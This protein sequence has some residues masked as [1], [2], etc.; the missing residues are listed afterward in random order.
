MPIKSIVTFIHDH[1][2]DQHVLATAAALADAN[3]AHLT[4]VC[5]G[6]DPT[7]PGA[8]YAGA[9][10]IVLESSLGRAQEEA[11]ATQKAVEAQLGVWTIPWE[12][13]VITSQ[14][15]ALSIAVGER[16][17][18]ADLIVLPKPYGKDRGAEDVV[19]TEAALFRTRVPVL[20]VPEGQNGA[21]EPMSVVVAWNQGPEALAAVRGAMPFLQAAEV[22]DLA[23]I[24]PPQHG[25][26]RSDPG[27]LLATML[28]RYNVRGNV[29]ILSKTM[30]RVSDVLMR[31]CGD[32]SAQLL[33]MGAYGHSR[34]LEAVLGGTTRNLLEETKIPVLMAH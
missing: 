12:T 5:L 27:G 17:Q 30:P 8:Y 32:K 24:D 2:R 31:H 29:T 14:I 34:L 28:S 4:A 13:M 20:V 11:V 9:N 18:M 22:V 23:I 16:A 1:A 33:V 15:G 10:A 25:A 3:G 21:F 6:I 26:D 7:N 19:I